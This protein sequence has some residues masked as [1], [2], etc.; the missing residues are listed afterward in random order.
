MNKD[1]I[2][3]LADQAGFS[4]WEGIVGGGVADLEVF[5]KLILEHD[6]EA[7]LLAAAQRITEHNVS[8]RTF[9]LRLLDPD[10][11]GHAVTAEVRQ[12]ASELVNIPRQHHG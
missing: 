9:L 11:L 8:M 7:S 12:L 5:A 1:T 10:E 3:K 2:H 4:V 6:R